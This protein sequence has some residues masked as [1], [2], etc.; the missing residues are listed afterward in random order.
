MPAPRILVL[1]GPNLDILGRRDPAQYGTVTLQELE[2]LVRTTAEP[3][4]LEVAFRQ[5][6]HEGELVTWLHEALDDHA[7]V[8]INPAAYAH[9]SVALHDA[10]EA[11]TVPVVE[12]H[13]SNVFKREPFR[14]VDHVATAATAVIEGAGA[15]GYR[16]AV[17]HLATLLG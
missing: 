10:V 9:T 7:G 17:L 4:G 13:L 14:H 2:D 8:V 6:N 1:N 5:S 15:D 3:L 11:L 12:V 16:L